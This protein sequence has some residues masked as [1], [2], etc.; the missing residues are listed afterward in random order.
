MTRS[1]STGHRHDEERVTHTDARSDHR[2]WPPHWHSPFVFPATA[3]VRM[4]GLVVRGDA[5]AVAHGHQDGTHFHVDTIAHESGPDAL[6]RTAE[7]CARLEG[8]VCVAVPRSILLHRHFQVPAVDDAEIE[9]MLPHLLAQ[10]LPSSVDDFAWT[11]SR[12]KT[13]AERAVLVKVFVARNSQLDEFV[14]PLL[15]AGI[16]VVDLVPEGWARA[17]LVERAEGPRAPDGGP[18]DLSFVI[19][20]EGAFRLVVTRGAD[21]LYDNVVTDAEPI[22]TSREGVS[23]WNPA[24]VQLATAAAEFERLFEAPLPLPSRIDDEG[25]EPTEDLRFAAAVAVVGL[26]RHR[27]MMPPERHRANRRRLLLTGLVDV[28]LLLVIAALVGLAFLT[29]DTVRDR[30]H[31]E[32]I[33]RRLDAQQ[34]RVDDLERKAETIREHERSASDDRTALRVL[35]SLRR[36]V[37]PDV[38]LAHLEYSKGRVVTLRGAAP[39]TG[40]VLDM[41]ETLGS[42]ATWLDL[43]VV[44]LQARPGN[45]SHPVHFVVEGR[46]R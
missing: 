43:R 18:V 4:T 2:W 12:V 5:C 34:A 7:L 6:E 11:W 9:A 25:C 14:A 37:R 45:G 39:E 46:V 44:Q 40:A 8:P 21:L 15:G 35:E 1:R 13:S 31:L 24:S 28:G 29:A 22:L 19:P 10:D 20:G 42:D 23:T 27:A 38:V 16:P 26:E 3:L 32:T 36:D 41:T 17:H 30:E 33:E